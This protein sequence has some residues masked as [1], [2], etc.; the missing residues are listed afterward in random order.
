MMTPQCHLK[1]FQLQP[2][3]H[4]QHLWLYLKLSSQKYSDFIQS[5][6][7]QTCTN[8]QAEN[9]SGYLKATCYFQGFLLQA[10]Q[11]RC[12]YHRYE[13]RVHLCHGFLIRWLLINWEKNL[14]KIHP[15][16]L[17]HLPKNPFRIWST[18]IL[19]NYK[20]ECLFQMPVIAASL[21]P[22]FSNTLHLLAYQSSI[23]ELAVKIVH[24]SVYVYSAHQE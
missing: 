21:Q 6:C 3:L 18:P 7:I 5:C 17:L 1:Q 19:C 12:Y 15:K 14:W 20:L 16:L 24:L 11:A 4:L 8:L 22:N 13:L 9:I 23:L 2:Q 10:F